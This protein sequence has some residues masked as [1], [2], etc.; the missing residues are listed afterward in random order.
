M[1]PGEADTAETNYAA[2]A[3]TRNLIYA[4]DPEGNGVMF[5]DSRTSFNDVTDGTSETLL[6]GEIDLEQDDP[7]KTKYPQYCP[8]GKCYIGNHWSAENRMS[9]YRG[10]NESNGQV[11]YQWPGPTSHHPG[12]AQFVFVDGHVDF[13]N[14]DIEL[15]LLWALTTRAGG[16]VTVA[17]G[18]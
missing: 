5:V 17:F 18:Q 6:V 11:S 3:T 7:I 4:I 10:I 16:E 8:G 2:V 9:T 13:L 12:G 15:E 1:I 14:E